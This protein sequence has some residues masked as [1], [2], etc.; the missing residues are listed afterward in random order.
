MT[1]KQAW[2][3]MLT[4]LNKVN[5]PSML[6]QD[7]NY[8]FNKAI[9]QYINKRYNIYDISQQTSDD[10]RVLKATAEL[11]PSNIQNGIKGVILPYDYLHLL[12]CICTFKINS[13]KKFKCYKS[14]ESVQF[15]AKRLTADSWSVILNDYYN[16]PIPQRPYYYI[17]NTND[18]IQET[19]WPDVGNS[20]QNTSNTV[21]L[22]ELLNSDNLGVVNKENG[23]RYGNAS[24]IRIE[25][26]YGSDDILTLDKVHIDYLKTPKYYS[27]TQDQLDLTDDVSQVLEFPDYVC[28]QIINELVYLVLE[29]NSD[30]RLKT[31]PVVTQ[32]IASPVQQQ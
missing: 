15:S 8:F 19:V 14:G 3:G 17:H 23:E 25:I 1:I 18:L 27:L 20:V 9:D 7:F 11:I 5:A 12:N 6:L 16:R 21:T 30:P 26:R 24:N 10:L 22:S 28:Q 31:N 4:E 32:S 29:N 2:E 13:G